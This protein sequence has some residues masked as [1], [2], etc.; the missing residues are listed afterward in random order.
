MI[1]FIGM[2]YYHDMENFWGFVKLKKVLNKP[3]INIQE[4][5]FEM[6]LPE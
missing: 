4:Y 6:F 5:K 1:K 2:D 3:Y